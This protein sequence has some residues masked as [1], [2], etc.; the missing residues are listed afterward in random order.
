MSSP[1]VEIRIVVPA[2]LYDKLEEIEK[3]LGVTKEDIILRAI[4]KIIE[5]LG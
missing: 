3:K 1:L 4:T 2:R 5:E